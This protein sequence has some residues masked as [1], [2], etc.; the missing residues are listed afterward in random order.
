MFDV[1]HAEMCCTFETAA[2]RCILVKLVQS[3][4]SCPV[5]L[6]IRNIAGLRDAIVAMMKPSMIE[7]DVLACENIQMCIRLLVHV[8]TP[9]DIENADAYDC[10]LGSS[11][12][13]HA[14]SEAAFLAT[15]FLILF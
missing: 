11:I 6:A 14:K 4:E 10:L 13:L 1:V 9:D 5:E 8:L 7:L 15:C 3:L 2:C 12:G